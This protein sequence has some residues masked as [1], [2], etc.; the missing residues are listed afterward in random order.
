VDFELNA[1]QRA[2]VEAV[3]SLL[4]QHAGAR[5]A[6]ELAQTGGYDH[7]L[8][9]ALEAAGFAEI[10]RGDETGLLEAVLVSEAIAR[11]AGVVSAGA[12]LIVAPALC[13]ETPPGPIA[14]AEQ[15][16]AR[17]LRFACEA[18]SLLLA[19]GDEARLIELEA[20]GAEAVDNRFAL[21]MGRWRGPLPEGESLGP[22][23]GPRMLAHWRLALAAEL[24]G[25]MEAALDLTVA[26]LKERHQFGRAIGS[27][28]AVQH[29]LALCSVRAEGSRWLTYEAAARGADP[30]ACATAAAHA[31]DS[32]RELFRETHQLSGA[33]G[34]TREHDLHVWSMRLPLLRVELGGAAEHRRALAREHWAQSA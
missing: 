24:L 4:A 32:A 3:D 21:P 23:S 17:P 9:D 19:A 2:I 25:C 34:F 33:T 13:A 28:Q 16:D 1:D 27:F 30:V 26:Y 10:A 18:R 12:T 7:P 31:A 5:R 20:D 6:A 8:D 14:L 29:R 11:S 22:G 15:G